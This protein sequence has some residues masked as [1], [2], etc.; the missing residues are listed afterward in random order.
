MDI[1]PS[2]Q[3]EAPGDEEDQLEELEDGDNCISE[4]V[5]FEEPAQET[6]FSNYHQHFEQPETFSGKSLDSHLAK[7]HDLVSAGEISTASGHRKIRSERLMQKGFSLASPKLKAKRRKA[8][9]IE[10]HGGRIIRTAGRKDGH[11]KVCTARGTRDRR[12]R[13]SPKTAIQFYDVQD[14]L[15]Y[16]RPSKAIDWLMKEAKAAIDGLDEPVPTRNHFS[17]TNVTE[18]HSPANGKSQQMQPE[19]DRFLKS[20][21]GMIQNLEQLNDDNPNSSFGFFTNGA[22]PLS[23]TVFQAYA[24][25]DFNSSISRTEAP[26]DSILHPRYQEGFLSAPLTTLSEIFDANLEVAR[27]Q[28]IFT[29]NYANTRGAGEDYSSVSSLPLHC[30]APQL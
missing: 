3:L 13:L 22:A 23:S 5:A 15:G 26:E 6:L 28:R 21:C 17:A 12:L 24:N 10:V 29:W 19:S 16:D 27:L 25:D 7:W 11:S 18:N 9:I 1:P 30:P 14:R 2:N 20:E 4:D 8:E